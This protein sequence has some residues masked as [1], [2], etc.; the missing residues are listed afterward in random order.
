MGNSKN[1]E[2]IEDRAKK[3]RKKCI[4]INTVA[5]SDILRRIDTKVLLDLHEKINISGLL[6][7]AETWNLTRTNEQQLKRIQ[8]QAIKC[9][10]NLPS[11]TPTI[12]ILYSL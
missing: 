9:L 8:I 4:C 12:A 3:T 6:Y 1:S 2:T 10:F 11:K 7:N 5:G